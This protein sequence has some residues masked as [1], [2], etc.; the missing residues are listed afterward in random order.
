MK[1][2]VLINHLNFIS[3]LFDPGSNVGFIVLMFEVSTLF[4]ILVAMDFF[5]VAAGELDSTDH[6]FVT[7]EEC[8]DLDR[9]IF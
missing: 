9:V 5:D 1:L 4:K 8:Q 7:F 3:V 2:R 6:V